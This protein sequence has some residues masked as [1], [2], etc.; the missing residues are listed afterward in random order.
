MTIEVYFV[1]IV[2]FI[3][4]YGVILNSTDYMQ[5]VTSSRPAILILATSVA[6]RQ[7]N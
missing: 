1:I 6:S 3:K 5:E 4:E 2:I 7:I